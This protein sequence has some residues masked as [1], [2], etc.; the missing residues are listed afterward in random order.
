VVDIWRELARDL[1][2]AG[3]GA[4]AE[5]RQREL[6]DELV[7]LG[8][9]VDSPAVARFVERLDGIGRALD[10]YANPELALD[11]LLLEWPHLATEPRRE[12]AA[13]RRHGEAA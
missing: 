3:R 8:R 10:A 7:P 13:D 2:L 12:E 1:A 5:L 4:T 9:A 6:I 11:A